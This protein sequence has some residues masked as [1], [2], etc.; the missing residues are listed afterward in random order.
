MSQELQADIILISELEY[1][2]LQKIIP[3][4]SAKYWCKPMWFCRYFMF[5]V[6]TKSLSAI[7]SKFQILNP[8]LTLSLMSSHWAFLL[9]FIY[10]LVLLIKFLLISYFW[11]T[12]GKELDWIKIKWNL[13]AESTNLVNNEDNLRHMDMQ[14]LLIRK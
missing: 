10:K 3:V 9:L 11:G 7:S 5:I 6:T 8:V 14:Y 13:V 2:H 4:T 1:L 12:T